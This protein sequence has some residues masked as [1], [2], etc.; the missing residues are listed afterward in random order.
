MSGI[1]RLGKLPER[2]APGREDL[3]AGAAYV[4]LAIT[5]VISKRG[6][7][8][9]QLAA[10]LLVQRGQ[11]QQMRLHLVDLDPARFGKAFQSGRDVNPI[12]EHIAALDQHVAE[13]NRHA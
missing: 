2:Q 9:D 10:A 8:A 3:A 7:A 1:A 13:V 6:G 4:P 5:P 12:P 11:V